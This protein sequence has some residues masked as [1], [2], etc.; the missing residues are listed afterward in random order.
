MGDKIDGNP[1]G[2]LLDVKQWASEGLMD[3][4]LAAGYY[5]DGGDAIKAC[6]AL[7]DETGGKCDVWYYGWVPQT[8]AD[9]QRDAA[10]ARQLGAGHI[11]YW[12]ADYIDDRINAG[13]LK[14][15]MSAAAVTSG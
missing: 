5:R 13:D 2:L 12:E 7:N 15:V 9:F 6:R 11:L 14:A 10:E 4:A 1:R 8:V 3:A